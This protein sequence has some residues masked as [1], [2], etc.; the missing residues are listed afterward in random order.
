MKIEGDVYTAAAVSNAS[1]R[2]Q[3]EKKIQNPF[4]Q[5]VK[6]YNKNI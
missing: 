2:V 3:F 1:K 4:I 5:T 6:K